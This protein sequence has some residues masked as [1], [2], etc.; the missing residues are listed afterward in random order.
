MSN[1]AV[2]RIYKELAKMVEKKVFENVNPHVKQGDQIISI[3]RI[4]NEN[5]NSQLQSSDGTFDKLK[6]RL[7]PGCHMKDRDQILYEDKKYPTAPFFLSRL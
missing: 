3:S 7:V 4:L 5:L 6:S 2:Q 1:E